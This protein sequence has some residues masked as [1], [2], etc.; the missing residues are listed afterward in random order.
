MPTVLREDTPQLAKTFKGQA[1]IA[2]EQDLARA[3]GD[4]QMQAVVIRAGDFFGCGTGTWVDQV[5]VLKL[6]QGKMTYPG[7]LHIS[8]PWAYLPDLASTFAVI[9]NKRAELPAFETFHFGGHQLTGHDWV[10]A[11][12]DV[13]REQG[14]LSAKGVL[15]V[16]GMPWPLIRL[17]AVF[18]P[19]WAAL[20]E[21][22]YLCE[23][24]HRL[25]SAKLVALVGSEPHTA[26]STALRSGLQD[27]G[28]LG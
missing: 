4:G 20:L 17:G 7:D 1:R 9:A 16:G 12:T 24:A 21:M 5:M 2:M 11:L 25:D 13:A 15:R 26:F 27:L 8:R 6:A 3:C 10:N 14:W 23:R 19:V 28:L 18:N 22:R